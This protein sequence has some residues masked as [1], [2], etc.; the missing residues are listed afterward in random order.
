M[1]E[2]IPSRGK[3]F[4]IPLGELGLF[5]CLFMGV[6]FGVMVFFATCFFAIFSLL[7]YN[8]LGHHA[9]DLAD[10]YRDVAFPVGVVA[11]VA[12]VAVMFGMWLRRKLSRG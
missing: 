4:G 12:G 10:A 8:E 7:F 3:L 2:T 1:S 5:S 9:V 6:A 11:L